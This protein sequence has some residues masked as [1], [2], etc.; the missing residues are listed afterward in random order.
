M[1]RNRLFII[2]IIF[3]NL[4]FYTNNVFAETSSY[5]SL[6]SEAAVLMDAQTGQVLYE[7]N[8]NQ[9]E[10]PASI[11]KIMTAMLALEKGSLNDVLIM[12]N[13]AVFS[14]ERD[15]SHIA[16]DVGERLSLEQALYAM[17]IESANDA[18]NGV[19]EYISGDLDSF[20]KLMN[21]RAIVTC[22]PILV[23]VPELVEI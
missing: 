9:R 6:V 21:E 14:I 1:W 23:P 3:V 18:A 8:M 7:K 5:P 10:Y 15:S 20:A 17:S 19:A 12:S 22:P 11:T 2:A 16:L 4:I 13:E